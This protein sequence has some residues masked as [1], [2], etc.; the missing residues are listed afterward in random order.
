[1]LQALSR[2][3]EKP[4]KELDTIILKDLV[5]G[6]RGSKRRVEAL[7]E[8]LGLVT[9]VLLRWH[10]CGCMRKRQRPIPSL[11]TTRCPRQHADADTWA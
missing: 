5:V 3:G 2:K 1:M 4:A 9:L 8:S 6:S 7:Q 11:W 10:G